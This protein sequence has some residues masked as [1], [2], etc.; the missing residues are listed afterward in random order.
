MEKLYL[1]L[2]SEGCPL[3]QANLES[4]PGSEV[5]QMRLLEEPDMDF[6]QV[7]EIQM[8]SLDVKAAS[9]KGVVTI[10][11]GRPGRTCGFSRTSTATSTPSPGT[12]GASGASW[13]R[14]SAAAA[15]PFTAR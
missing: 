5:V 15:R 8:I 12:G 7:G 3:A 4:P 6:T 10:Q 9:K 1:I 13:A 2:D 14:T 11:R